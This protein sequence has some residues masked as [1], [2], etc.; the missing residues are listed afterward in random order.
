MKIENEITGHVNIHTS[1]KLQIELCIKDEDEQVDVFVLDLVNKEVQ[2]HLENSTRLLIGMNQS[3]D[4]YLKLIND[5]GLE[6]PKTIKR[7]WTP[8]T[9]EG[10]FHFDSS[11]R[12]FSDSI[13]KNGY[14]ETD[15]KRYENYNAFP[16]RELAEKG[17]N[18]S[19]LD[20]LILLWQ[21]ANDCI[22]EP[23]WLDGI[24]NKYYIVYDSR[25]KYVCYDFSLR[26]KSNNE[27]FETSEQ[28]KAFIKVYDEE[29]KK[30]MGVI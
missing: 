13:N 15:I 11:G 20:R 12:I 23:D 18:L 7:H 19:K 8:K 26:Q 6:T 21:Y 10:Y 28:V 3:Y 17:V 14:H 22:F 30:I 1:S 16:T 5:L 24:Q 27:H 2:T 25:D 9:G 29:I 4:A